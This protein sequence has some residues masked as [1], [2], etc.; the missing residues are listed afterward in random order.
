[1][2]IFISEIGWTVAVCLTKCSILLFYW[3]LFQSLGQLFR[4]TVR[5]L[6]A[7]MISWGLVVVS[8]NLLVSLID[9]H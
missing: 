7:L 1:M 8:I 5:V 4:I 9:E 2:G 3:R 6:V